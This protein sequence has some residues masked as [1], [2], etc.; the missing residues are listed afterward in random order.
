MGLTP[1]A[2]LPR[3]LT[4]PNVQIDATVLGT[5]P[6]AHRCV[7][8]CMAWAPQGAS[9]TCARCEFLLLLQPG[10]APA[11]IRMSLCVTALVVMMGKVERGRFLMRSRALSHSRAC[12]VSRARV[13]KRSLVRLK[14]ATDVGGAVGA[15]RSWAAA[16]KHLPVALAQAN[17]HVLRKE[18]GVCESSGLCDSSWCAAHNLWAKMSQCPCSAKASLSLTLVRVLTCSEDPAASG[19]LGPS[20]PGGSWVRGRSSWRMS[21]GKW[22]VRRE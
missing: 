2:G 20:G 12:D 4:C 6:S 9:R 18:G 13:G 10:W 3:A 16:R 17:S 19:G 1:P 14:V 8:P 5:L 21:M 11:L 22:K 7:Q 15:V